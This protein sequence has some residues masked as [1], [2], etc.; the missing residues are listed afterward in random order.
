MEYTNDWEIKN[1]RYGDDLA[2]D[3]LLPLLTSNQI[4]AIKISDF[5][6]AE[7]LATVVENIKKQGVSWYQNAEF[8]QG[9][10]GISATGYHS[11]MDGKALYFSLVPNATDARKEMFVGVSDPLER[12]ADIFGEQYRVSVAKESS[13]GGA[14]YFSGLI[15]AMGAESTLHHDW[16]PNQLPGWDVSQSEEQFA[17][18][19]YLQ[20][21]DKGGELIVYNHPWTP[22]DEENN[23]DVVEKGPNGFDT[24]FLSSERPTKITPVSGDL[25]IFRSRN[26]HQVEAMDS[27]HSRLTFNTFLM[28]KDGKLSLWS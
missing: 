7:E 16:A 17:L 6:N 27:K 24:K 1:L 23:K 12:I 26:F 10:I 11:K 20:M 8:K 4:A 3:T 25:V 9:R 13:V 18:V 2:M 21:P 28:L 19:L 22:E 14:E 5:F 15:R